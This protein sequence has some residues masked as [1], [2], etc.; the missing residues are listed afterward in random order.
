MNHLVSPMGRSME[1]CIVGIHSSQGIGRSSLA[2]HGGACR[3][4]ERMFRKL[5]KAHILAMKC[6]WRSSFRWSQTRI[7]AFYLVWLIP[8][9]LLSIS[10]QVKRS[11]FITH[12]LKYLFPPKRSPREKGCGSAAQQPIMLCVF[13]RFDN[14]E[15]SKQIS[16]HNIC[17]WVA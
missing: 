6:W 10:Q 15:N 17:Y 4:V 14:T 2:E 5:I 7:F 8:I 11:N 9:Q 13:S 1:C 3:L 12:R 16:E